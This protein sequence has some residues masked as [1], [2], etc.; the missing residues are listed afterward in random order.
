MSDENNI[1]NEITS[2]LGRSPLMASARIELLLWII[3]QVKMGEET[4]QELF[5]TMKEKGYFK[6]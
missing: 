1:I 3:F 4:T 6:R 2:S 5:Q